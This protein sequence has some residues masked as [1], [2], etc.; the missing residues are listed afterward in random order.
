[1]TTNEAA[2]AKWLAAAQDKPEKRFW[3]EPLIES[4]IVPDAVIRMAIRK[5]L[6][7]RLKEEDRRS[8]PANRAAK[9]AFIEEMKRSPIAL[10]TDSANAQHYEVPAE[11]FQIVLGPRRKYSSAFFLTAAIRWPKRKRPCSA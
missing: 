7:E 5:M 4:G 1:M 6:R 8:E 10:H 3:Y 11:F 2:H 9:L